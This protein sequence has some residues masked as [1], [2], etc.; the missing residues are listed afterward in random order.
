MD[1]IGEP[2]VPVLDGEGETRLVGLADLFRE[3]PDLHDLALRPA[4]RVAVTRLLMAITYAALEGPADGQQWASCR[5]RIVPAALDYLESHRD[6]FQLFGDRPFMQVANLETTDNAS[7]DKLDFTLASGNNDTL[8]DHA[9]GLDGRE[10]MPAS[11]ALNLLTYQ[12]FS[13]GGLVGET[14]WCGTR[15]GRTSEHAPAIEGSLLHAVLR[16]GSVLDLIHLNL[17]P[18]D[19]LPAPLG[20][21]VWELEI[22]GPSSEAAQLACV[23]VLGRLVPLSRAIRLVPDDHRMTLANGLSYAKVTDGGREL[24]ATIVVRGQGNRQEHA[25]LPIDLSKHPWRELA[26][27]GSRSAALTARGAP[28]HYRTCTVSSDPACSTCG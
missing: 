19:L 23:T 25:Y 20:Q 16:G 24:S 27:V 12:C 17:V 28:W 13:P 26:S 5:E 6:A 1:L 2:W 11:V 15:T 8:Y 9:G 22:D 4:Q 3:A 14:C 21:P 7:V 10:M 18:H